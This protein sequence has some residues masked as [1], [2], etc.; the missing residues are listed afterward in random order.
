MPQKRSIGSALR[1]RVEILLCRQDDCLM[2]LGF[3]EYQGG[4]AFVVL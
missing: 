4:A 1:R 3:R 2:S